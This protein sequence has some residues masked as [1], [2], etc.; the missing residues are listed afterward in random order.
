LVHQIFNILEKND[1]YVKPE[2]CAFKQEEIEYLGMIVGKG[3][4]SMDPKKLMVVANYT[5][6]WNTTDVHAFLGFMGY[7]RYF[8]PGYSQVA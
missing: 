1:L 6:P 2:K 5:V 8:I 3:K 4:T 7:Y